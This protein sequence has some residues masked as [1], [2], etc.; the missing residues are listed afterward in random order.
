[1]RKK[2]HVIFDVEIIGSYFLIVAYTIESQRLHVFEDR[3]QAGK[4]FRNKNITFITFNGISFDVPLVTAFIKNNR[5]GAQLKH[6]ANTI[7][8][9]KLQHWQTRERFDLAEPFFDHIDIKE[10][11][12]GVMLSLKTYEG[13]MH[14]QHLQDMPFDHN[15][16][17]DDNPVM[18]KV[19][20]E[21]CTNDVM[22]TKQLYDIIRPEIALREDM[23]DLY[24]MDLRSK[25][26]PQVAEAVL[27]KVCGIQGNTKSIPANVSYKAPE[28]IHSDNPQI[29][30][31][32]KQIEAHSF[33]INHGN[34]SPV[35]PAFLKEPVTINAGTYQFGIGGLHSKHDVKVHLQESDEYKLVDIDV[36]SYYPALMLKAGLTPDLADGKGEVFID[37]Y[38]DIYQSRLAAKKRLPNETD[39][40]TRNATI[41]EIASKKL[42]ANG[43][44]GKLGSQYCAFY[45]PELMLAVT[46]SGQLHLLTLIDEL[47]RIEG[48]T[49]ESANTDGIT[50]RYPPAAL[51][52]I[53]ETLQAST[54]ATQFEYEE[55]HYREV[56]YR[57]VNSYLA[58]TTDGKIK[59]KGA[60]SQA[61]VLEGTNPTFQICAEAAAQYLLHR[62]PPRETVTACTDIT[63]FIAIR[64]VTG[65]GTQHLSTRPLD[66][67]E[68]VKD[69][70][71]A[72]N[73][74]YSAKADKLVKRKSRPRPLMIG[75][76]GKSF[77]RVARW[78]RSTRNYMPLSYV[79]SGNKVP[80]TDKAHLCLELPDELPVDIDFDW[81]VE[82]A[83]KMLADAGV[84]IE[85]RSPSAS[86]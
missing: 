76:G 52:Q 37:T 32:I 81:Y 60:F 18:E 54:D 72:A 29:L 51:E 55:T 53:R 4:F 69:T 79:S 28:F 74:W 20:I 7:I 25:S 63:Q 15:A 17:I 19:C 83:E 13:R 10:P 21:Y 39:E 44:F 24:G 71:T 31:L 64:N 14:F 8:E 78:Y 58:V 1:M 67:W 50:L 46:L 36:A 11:S 38:R 45:A 16:D 66:D 12:P 3:E 47:E 77:G 27:K 5:S 85:M 26:G 6:I 23:S 82:R 9:E 2:F 43:L 70:G 41:T 65:G 56:A 34:G 30:D 75:S 84:T 22:A 48:V 80:D 59:R 73:E 42:M 61:G 62:T 57:D 33:V 49:S 40:E 35:F 86:I 68:L